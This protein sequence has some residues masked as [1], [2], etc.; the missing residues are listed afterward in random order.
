MA[1]FPKTT[2]N[3]TSLRA[4]ETTK[5]KVL[6]AID[7]RV[8]ERLEELDQ[9]LGFAVTASQSFADGDD[10]KATRDYQQSWLEPVAGW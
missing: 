3:A 2:T 5:K 7:E 9:D 4:R 8:D 1:K 10:Y 6:D